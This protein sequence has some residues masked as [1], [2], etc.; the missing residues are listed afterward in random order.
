MESTSESGGKSLELAVEERKKKVVSVVR[1]K[2]A[3]SS[4]TLNAHRRCSAACA[5]PL[6]LRDHPL[7]PPHQLHKLCFPGRLDRV[8][9]VRLGQDDVQSAEMLQL[10]KL[11]HHAVRHERPVRQGSVADAAGDGHV[12][13]AEVA[14]RLQLDEALVQ[15]GA[16]RDGDGACGHGVAAGGTEAGDE[17]LRTD[18]GDREPI[19]AVEDFFG[20]GEHAS[21]GEEQAEDRRGFAVLVHGAHSHD[22]EGRRGGG[23]VQDESIDVGSHLRRKLE[24][25]RLQLIAL[26]RPRRGLRRIGCP[27]AGAIRHQRRL[28]VDARLRQ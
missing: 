19:D 3:S 14:Q 12:E 24:E 8:Q 2:P 23:D 27:S 1:W 21:T 28:S 13:G 9:P 15:I 22:G 25:R 6:P 4:H 5:R 10:R 18:P 16:R 17:G 20:F 11:V 7:P 26:G